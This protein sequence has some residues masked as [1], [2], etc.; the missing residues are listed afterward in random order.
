MSAYSMPLCTIF[1]KC[2]APS[3]PMCVQHGAPSTCAEIFSRIGPNDSYDFAE[4]PGMIDGPFNAPSSPPDTPHPTKWMP[5]SCNAACRRR[6]SS[7]FAFPPSMMMSPGSTNSANSSITASVGPPAFT[8]IRIFR[9]TANDATK[10]ADDSDGTNVPSPPCSSI[11]AVVFACVRLCTAVT[12]PL[13]AKLR[14][15][16]DPITARPVTPISAFGAVSL[17]KKPPDRGED[18][19]DESS[20]FRTGIRGARRGQEASAALTADEIRAPSA[21]P[22]AS[23]CTCLMTRPICRM[24]TG[25]PVLAATPSIAEAT[26]PATSSSV[27]G[28]GR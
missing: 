24:V 14:A 9:G 10:S 4:P 8:M 6:V 2:P 5:L 12:N 20:A 16:F 25:A 18:G 26:S 7:N 27:S 13:R 21:R 28:V 19:A 17:M 15:R 22:A 3:V 23:A 1:T 11:N